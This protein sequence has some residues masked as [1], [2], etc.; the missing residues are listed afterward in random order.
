MLQTEF[1]QDRACGW[2]SPR[3][4]SHPS[5]VEPSIEPMEARTLFLGNPRRGGVFRRRDGT[6]PRRAEAFGVPSAYCEC[7]VWTERPVGQAHQQ[8]RCL[9]ALLQRRLRCH[10]VTTHS[11]HRVTSSPSH[12][13]HASLTHQKKLLSVFGMACRSFSH[14]ISEAWS[15]TAVCGLPPASAHATEAERLID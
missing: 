6:K 5:R 13:C 14:R 4:G 12:E 7:Q 15:G 2:G 11:P 9:V 8:Q 1:E 3:P 10:R